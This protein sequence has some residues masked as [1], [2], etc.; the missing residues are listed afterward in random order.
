MT[1]NEWREIET[2]KVAKQMWHIYN[3]KCTIQLLNRK[4]KDI[5]RIAELMGRRMNSKHSIILGL[6]FNSNWHNYQDCGKEQT[7]FDLV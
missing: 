6:P 5:S 2:W 4:R 3:E 7:A 1:Y